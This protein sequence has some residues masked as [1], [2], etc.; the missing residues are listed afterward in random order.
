[1]SAA[2]QIAYGEYEGQGDADLLTQYL[3]SVRVARPFSRTRRFSRLGQKFLTVSRHGLT[4]IGL[5]TISQFLLLG[6][7]SIHLVERRHKS[8]AIEKGRIAGGVQEPRE[9]LS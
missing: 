6:D 7:P 3:H 4:A 9:I 8:L 2:R 1:M 5:K